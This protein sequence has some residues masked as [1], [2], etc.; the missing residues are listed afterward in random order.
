LFGGRRES[1]VAQLFSLGGKTRMKTSTI[2]FSVANLIGLLLCVMFVGSIVQLAKMEQRDYYDASDSFTFLGTAGPILVVCFIFDTILG[3]K[4]LVDIIR[5]RDYQASL[6][7]G[8]VAVV[9]V[10]SFIIMRFVP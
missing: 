3:I 6:A 7:L 2:I 4:A 9:W 5:R 8:A 10:A 1:A